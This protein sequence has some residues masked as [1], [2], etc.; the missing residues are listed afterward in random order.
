M[1]NLEAIASNIVVFPQP[2]SPTIVVS[3][4]PKFMQSGTLKFSMANPITTNSG[5][6]SYLNILSTLSK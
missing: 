2:F 5:A 4:E 6:A 3:P 1:S